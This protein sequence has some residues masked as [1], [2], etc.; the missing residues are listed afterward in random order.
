M[1]ILLAIAEGDGVRLNEWSRDRFMVKFGM[2]IASFKKFK[3]N[4]GE[5]CFPRLRNWVHYILPLS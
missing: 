4:T 1:S 5:A 2:K 3:E